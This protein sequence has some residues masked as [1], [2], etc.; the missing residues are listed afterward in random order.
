ELPPYNLIFISLLNSCTGA[1]LTTLLCILIGY[2]MALALSKPKKNTQIFFLVLIIIPYRTSFL[3]RT[4]S[5]V[6]LLGNNTLN[7]II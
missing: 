6:T 2:P 3:L 7:Q 1:F 4:Y 5:W